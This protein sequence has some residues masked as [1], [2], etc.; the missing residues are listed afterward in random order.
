MDRRPQVDIGKMGRHAPG[1]IRIIGDEDVALLDIVTD[2]LQGPG[3][4]HAD[5]HQHAIA[6]RRGEHLTGSRHENR[7]VVLCFLDEDSVRRSR[8]H[9]RHLVDNGL[10]AVEKDFEANGIVHQTR[11]PMRFP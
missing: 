8:N 2:P 1:G 7:T 3:H 11:S 10:K 4:G 5:H 9:A 6:A